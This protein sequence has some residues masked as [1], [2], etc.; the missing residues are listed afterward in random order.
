[1]ENKV[2]TIPISNLEFGWSQKPNLESIHDQKIKS[3]SEIQKDPIYP[4]SRIFILPY[5]NLKSRFHYQ[6]S[7]KLAEIDNIYK[8]CPRNPTVPYVPSLLGYSFPQ[9]INTIDMDGGPGG[10]LE[11]V[12]FRYPQAITMGITQRENPK[13]IE[14]GWDRQ[15]IDPTRLMRFVGEDFTGNLATQWKSFTNELEDEFPVG[16]EFITANGYRKD[17]LWIEF[18]LIVK[19]LKEG[20]NAIM[21]MDDFSYSTLEIIYL[22]TMLFEDVY[23]F[24]P[25]VSGSD[26]DEYYLIM[27]NLTDEKD[28]VVAGMEKILNSNEKN[29]NSIL[30]NNLPQEFM[31]W[32]SKFQD[33]MKET[34]IETLEKI[35]NQLKIYEP[36]E[37]E[38]QVNLPQKLAEWALPDCY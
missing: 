33:R 7:L 5:T 26:S 22:A 2:I 25:L 34:K 35:Q 12:Q 31:I 4:Q 21:R 16:V 10:F 6:D 27:K 11:Y 8:V 19:N 29:K 18:Y 37:S 36:M 13:W 1:M 30:K 3:L 9:R 24:Q 17:L 20:Y 38:S 32:M 15:A 28:F 14:G 23:L